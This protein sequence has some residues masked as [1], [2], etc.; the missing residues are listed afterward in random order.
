MRSLA[1]KISLAVLILLLV[2]CVH[3]P[4][5]YSNYPDSRSYRSGAVIQ[6]SYYPVERHYEY[7][8]REPQHWNNNH[9]QHE[10]RHGR[11]N[12]HQHGNQGQHRNDNNRG[13]GNHRGRGD[14]GNDR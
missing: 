1:I 11:D 3:Y 7:H 6:R 5:Q 14:H 2:A 13:H 12:S 10:G 9:Y 4:Q 8:Y